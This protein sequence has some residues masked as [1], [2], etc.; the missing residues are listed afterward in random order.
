MWSFPGK[1][2]RVVDRT[3]LFLGIRT[4]ILTLG[5]TVGFLFVNK[6][7]VDIP[8]S[9]GG[10]VCLSAFLPLFHA[11]KIYL[12]ICIGVCPTCV[13]LCH[14]H[15]LVPGAQQSQKMPSSALQLEYRRAVSLRVDAET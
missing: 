13:S 8:V 10:V 15:S 12:F 9:K 2:F 3:E 14:V 1:A 6:T 7:T 5:Y 4:Q 11:L